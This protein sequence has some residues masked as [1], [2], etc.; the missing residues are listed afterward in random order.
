[1]QVAGRAGRADAPG[2]VLVQTQW[3]DHPLYQALVAHDFDG[4]AATLL[5][6]R[7]QAGFPP[8]TFQALL[9]A[10]SPELARA[11]AF[12]RQAREA[13]EPLAEGVLISG[14]APA[15]MARLAQRERAQ[16][17]LES[18]QRGALH[19]LLDSLPPMLD[20]LAKAHGRALRWSLDVDPQEL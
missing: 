14:P 16:L 12:L 18:P 7:R 20:G 3:P 6:E 10:D 13:L 15:L 5:T 9:R 11:T 19:R 1:M 8:S 17:V 4:Y 2:E